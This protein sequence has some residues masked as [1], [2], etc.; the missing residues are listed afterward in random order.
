MIGR[1]CLCLILRYL[2]LHLRKSAIAYM[3][4]SQLNHMRLLTFSHMIGMES[5]A[6]NYIKESS[7]IIMQI[8]K[9]RDVNYLNGLNHFHK[10][11]QPFSVESIFAPSNIE[12][13]VLKRLSHLNQDMIRVALIITSNVIL[14][15]VTLPISFVSQLTR[16]Y[17]TSPKL[18]KMRRWKKDAPLIN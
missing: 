10:F 12:K 14:K 8:A 6:C 2:M 13:A 4:N 18:R 7:K 11:K 5:E 1:R 16:F 17:R 9:A 3:R 15:T